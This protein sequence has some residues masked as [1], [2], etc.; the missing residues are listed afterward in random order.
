MSSS[1]YDNLLLETLAFQS[2]ASVRTIKVGRAD[3][4]AQG[5]H[6]LPITSADSGGGAYLVASEDGS[7]TRV[8]LWEFSAQVITALI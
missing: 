5:E 6:V 4:G 1:S 3:G 8:L 7:A 2:P